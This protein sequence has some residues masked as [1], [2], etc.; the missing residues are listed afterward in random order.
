MRPWADDFSACG[1][2]ELL[3]FQSEN[4][5]WSKQL[6]QRT[7]ALVNSRLAKNMSQDDYLAER[8]QVHE[9]TAECRNRANILEAQIGRFAGLLAV[10][11][12]N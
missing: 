7:N 5:E 9:E 11:R 10:A 8:K 2:D 6:R 1:L 12:E 4:R 3:R